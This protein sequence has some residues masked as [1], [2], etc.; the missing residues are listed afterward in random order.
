M[1]FYKA[2]LR[3]LL[4]RCDPEW[5]HNRAI[6]LG[7]GVGS[8]ALGR[9]LLAGL[10]AYSDPRLEIEVAGLRCP[11]PVGLAAGFDKNGHVIQAAAA[12]GCG[13]VEIGS[14]SAQPA[15]GNPKPRLFR[16]PADEA[17]VVNYGVPNDGAQVIARR[18]AAR[19]IPVPLGVNLVETNTGRQAAAD[20]VVIELV[21]AVRP[22]IGRADY[23]ALNLNCPNTTGGSSPFDLSENLRALMQEYAKIKDLPPI[24]LKLTA[25]P[26]PE[27]IEQVLE[28]V[29]PFSFVKGFI[30]NLPPGKPY[31]LNS[32]STL[33]DSMPGTLCGRPVRHL[34]NETIRAWYS[35]MDRR[36][37]AIIGVGGI[38][39]AE[40]A[41]V[42]IRLG[43]SLVQL[44]TALVYQGPGLVGKI[45]RKLAAL[46]AR[47]GVARVEQA[48]GVDHRTEHAS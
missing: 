3:P 20:E 28:A 27:R 5:I 21:Q 14:V 8:M 47:D 11:N 35:R 10:Y 2:C 48:V 22:F 44:Y 38:A 32:P 7:A 43:A 33:V 23:F 13:L 30:F 17:I 40:D 24:F 36:R 45:N 42:K 25:N 41:Y 19:P 16:L 15:V 18:I 9:R 39:S 26:A 29:E 46:L 1:G 37:Y 4:F 12:L 6:F 34:I 31:T